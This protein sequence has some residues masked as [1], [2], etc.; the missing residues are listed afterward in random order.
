MAIAFTIDE[1]D[2]ARY[3]SNNFLKIV[4]QRLRKKKYDTLIL[5]GGCN[6]ISNIKLGSVILP[7]D[8][9]TWEEKVE[10]SR[11][12]MFDLATNKMSYKK[13]ITNAFIPIA[14]SHLHTSVKIEV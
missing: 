14:I 13:Q 12:N 5:H 3:K 1:D 10:K 6:E 9:K 4:P 8:V 2:D 11:S 7:N